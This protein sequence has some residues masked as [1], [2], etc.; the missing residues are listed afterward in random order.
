MGLDV[1]AYSHLKAVGL[2]ADGWCQDDNHIV[3]FAYADFPRSFAGIPVLCTYSVGR[4]FDETSILD[5]G[6]YEI[7]PETRVHDFSAGGYGSH[8]AWRKDLAR[9]FNPAAIINDDGTSIGEPDPDKPFYEL[10]WFAD[11]EGC[12]GELAAAELLADF[13]AHADTYQASDD[14]DRRK[15]DHWTRACELAADGGLIRFH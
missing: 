11:N 10:I 5:G 3:A 6:C 2:H 4:I 13:R 15:Y 7:T 12:I 9:Q 8:C 1:T 14:W